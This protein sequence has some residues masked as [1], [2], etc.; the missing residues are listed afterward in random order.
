MATEINTFSALVDDAVIRTG[1]PSE[2]N[3][4]VAYTRQVIRELQ[5]LG[6]FY[7]DLVEDVLTADASPYLW[8]NPSLLRS[9]LTVKY[10][11]VLDTYNRPVFPKFIRPSIQQRDVT[12]FYYRSSTVVV[13]SGIDSGTEI[14]IAY[15]A[16]L[17]KLIYYISDS[18]PA[19]YDAETQTWSYLTAITDAEKAVAEAL[20]SNWLLVD[21]YDMILEGVCS[22]V[23]KQIQDPRAVASFSLFSKM[24]QDF[25][26]QKIP[27][28]YSG[29]TS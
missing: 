24:K 12:Y 3:N 5:G 28:S 19:T 1:R 25:L 21:W 11:T 7:D 2:L 16:W 17:P 29:K 8:T 14:D 15:F 27:D 4:I 9:I 13:F 10:P 20:V 18:R 6:Q 26:E 22:R 23:W